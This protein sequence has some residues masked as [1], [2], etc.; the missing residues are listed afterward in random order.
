VPKGYGI[1]KPI[2]DIIPQSSYIVVNV[3]D[4][5]GIRNA[6]SLTLNGAQ[7]GV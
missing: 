7:D 5:R 3:S 2:D 4:S 6:P 1:D